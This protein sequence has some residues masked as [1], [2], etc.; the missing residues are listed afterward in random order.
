MSAIVAISLPLITRGVP[1]S[2][3]SKSAAVGAPI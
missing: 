1:A 3:A 2:I